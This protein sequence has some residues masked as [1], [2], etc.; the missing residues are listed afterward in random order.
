MSRELAMFNVHEQLTNS[1]KDAPLVN[2]LIMERF[3]QHI[4]AA[5]FA[6]DVIDCSTLFKVSVLSLAQTCCDLKK[7]KG[8][9]TSVTSSGV[10]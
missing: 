6:M 5:L 7:F 9:Y 8:L 4:F 10:I 2:F 1:S 3:R